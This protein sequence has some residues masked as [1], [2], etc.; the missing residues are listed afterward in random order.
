[1]LNIWPA[2]ADIHGGNDKAVHWNGISRIA[3]RQYA[4]R[5][6][7][8]SSILLISGK[9]IVRLSAAVVVQS[10]GPVVHA[11]GKQAKNGHTETSQHCVA[12]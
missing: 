12:I 10:E 8:G 2:G 5:S 11:F 3:Y 6:Q 9:E 7:A 4:F 1:M